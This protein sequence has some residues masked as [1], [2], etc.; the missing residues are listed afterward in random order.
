MA[1]QSDP[2]QNTAF[3]PADGVFIAQDSRP[4]TLG[5]VS[6]GSLSP[7]VRALLIIDGTVTKYIEAYTNEPVAVL[8][9]EQTGSALGDDHQWLDA[10]RGARIIHRQ[11]M[12]VG[13]QTGCLRAYAESLIVVERLS[14]AMQKGLD[15]EP[16]GLGK[17]L[18]DS[19]I[20]TRREGLWFGREQLT[21]LPGPVAE[22]CDGDFLTRTYRVI[23]GG[24]PLMMITERFP[25]NGDFR[26]GN[27][28]TV[29]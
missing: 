24:V 18:F 14:P 9:L 29:D 4:A 21:D 13:D 3:D 16:G 17:I 10:P 15:S 7:F 20:E 28:A 23:A 22:L 25:F 19:G 27:L 5:D 6:V 26:T 1:I 12:L 11:S 8:R 2:I